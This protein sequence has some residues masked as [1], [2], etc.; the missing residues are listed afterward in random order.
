MGCS[1]RLFT[2]I[3]GKEETDLNTARA[4]G[5]RW[6]KYFLEHLRHSGNASASCA[7]AGIHVDTAY[8]HD[9][10]DSRFASEWKEAMAETLARVELVA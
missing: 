9:K 2:I 4:L 5:E 3:P 1:K 6:K 7:F 10:K 8:E